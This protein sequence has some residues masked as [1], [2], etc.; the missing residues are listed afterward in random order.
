L[1]ALMIAMAALRR[2]ESRGSHFRTDFPWRDAEA[3][4]QAKKPR[5]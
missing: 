1:V 5:A 2:Q 3:W 4:G